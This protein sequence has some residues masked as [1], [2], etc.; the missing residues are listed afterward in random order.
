MVLSDPEPAGPQQVSPSPVETGARR[1][2]APGFAS[3]TTC[4]GYRPVPAAGP[5]YSDGV[6]HTC[7]IC[8]QFAYALPSYAP[9]Y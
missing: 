3:M 6:D 9:R 7:V 8:W 2:P 4:T 5:R 1:P